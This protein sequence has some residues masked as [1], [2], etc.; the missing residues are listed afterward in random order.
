MA[1]RDAGSQSEASTKALMDGM[2]KKELY[3][4]SSFCL[5]EPAL[6]M[7]RI[8][9]HLRYLIAL[10]QAGVL[11]A[12]G[13]LFDNERMTGDGITIIR[14][15]TLQIAQAIAVKDP[16]A[17]SGMR[18]VSVRRWVVNEGRITVSVDLSNCR[19]ALP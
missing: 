4:I 1:Q 15:E 9:E 12:S 19:G 13:P 2:M 17:A 6:L 7:S 11:F 14:A 3:V 5:V 16:L 10:E 8:E 18:R